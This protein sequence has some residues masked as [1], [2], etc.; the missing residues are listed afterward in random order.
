MAHYMPNED[1]GDDDDDD[2]DDDDV[3]T[4]DIPLLLFS[5]STAMPTAA[6]LHINHLTGGSSNDAS[7]SCKQYAFERCWVHFWAFHIH[8]GRRS[9]DSWGS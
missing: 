3:K 6:P 5:S 1:D 9:F 2:D 7:R 8:I 4:W